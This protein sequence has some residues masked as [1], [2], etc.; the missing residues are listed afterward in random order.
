[1]DEQHTELKSSRIDLLQTLC[2]VVKE[3]R[4]VIDQTP[5]STVSL[6]EVGPS[7]ERI[8]EGLSTPTPHIKIQVLGQAIDLGTSELNTMFKDLGHIAMDFSTLSMYE[9]HAI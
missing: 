7:E 9:V 4:V 3:F 1:M 8:L 2:T 6:D 5:Y